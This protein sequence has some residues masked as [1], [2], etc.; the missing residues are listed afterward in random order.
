MGGVEICPFHV[1][2][3]SDFGVE[4]TFHVERDDPGLVNPRC[5]PFHVKHQSRKSSLAFD[6][7]S[8]WNTY[9]FGNRRGGYYRPAPPPKYRFSA[10]LQPTLE[11]VFH[12][13]LCWLEFRA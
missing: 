5:P 2:Q 6:V 11:M 4:A 1:E 9:F 10:S 12:V 7:G 3:L 13:K 8:T